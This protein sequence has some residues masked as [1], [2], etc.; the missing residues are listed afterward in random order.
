MTW[1]IMTVISILAVAGCDSSVQTKFAVTCSGEGPRGSVEHTFIIDGV[2]S[3]GFGYKD[4]WLYGPRG[5]YKVKIA[6][7]KISDGDG[8]ILDLAAGI[9]EQTWTRPGLADFTAPSYSYSRCIEG[10][11]PDVKGHSDAVSRPS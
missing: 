5:G 4:G 2:K 10:P 6:N 9:G 7:G 11:V 3:V 8:L 1:K